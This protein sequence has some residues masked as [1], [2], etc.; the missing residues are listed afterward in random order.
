MDL[1]PNLVWELYLPESRVW[2][3]L[4][5][6]GPEPVSLISTGVSPR[7]QVCSPAPHSNV[8]SFGHSGQICKVTEGLSSDFNVLADKMDLHD[9]VLMLSWTQ[10]SCEELFPQGCGS[11]G[12]RSVSINVLN[13]H[14]I[15]LTDENSFFLETYL[16]ERGR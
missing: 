13:A 14:F 1:T 3:F 16:F 2:A 9:T 8:S 7:G 6:G 15:L 4:Q 10:T 5:T 12:A 11:D